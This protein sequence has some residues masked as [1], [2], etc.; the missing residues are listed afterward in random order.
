MLFQMHGTV[1]RIVWIMCSGFHFCLWIGR[2][3]APVGLQEIIIQF[4]CFDDCGTFTRSS[5]SIWLYICAA[6]QGDSLKTRAS[7]NVKSLLEVGLL[8]WIPQFIAFRFFKRQN[9][10]SLILCGIN[11]KSY[12]SRILGRL[13]IAWFAVCAG[14]SSLISSQKGGWTFGMF[15]PEYEPCWLKFSGCYS[16]PP[17]KV[18]DSI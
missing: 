7:R 11:W 2:T 18:Q 13:F 14:V 3:W 4:A 9:P 16:V 1:T 5:C 8:F 12:Y 6:L 15:Q 17:D 10:V